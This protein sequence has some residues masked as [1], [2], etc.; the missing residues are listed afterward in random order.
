MNFIEALRQ[1]I[2]RQVQVVTTTQT[3]VG[4]L[5]SV[6]SGSIVVLTNQPQY[7]PTEE[8]TILLGN[9]SHVRVFSF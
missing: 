2:G 9:I 6:S 1:R 5:E 3:Y 4:I 7:G 8:V